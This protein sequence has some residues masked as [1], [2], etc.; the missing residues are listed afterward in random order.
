MRTQELNLLMIFD[1]IMVERSITRAAERLAMTQPA[2]SNAVSRMRALWKDELFVKNGRNIQPTAYAQNLW[3]KIKK[4]LGELTEAVDPTDFD[5]ATVKRTFKIAVSDIVV[6]A[7]WLPLRKMLKEQAPHINIHAIPYTDMSSDQMLEDAKVDLIIGVANIENNSTRREY[8]FSPHFV[9][10][11]RPGHPLNKENLSME[12]FCSA[13]HLFISLSGDITNT[14]DQVLAQHGLSRRIAFTVNHFAAITP[15][16]E[17]SDLLC[18]APSAPVI[19]AL[20]SGRLAG[21]K[22]PIELTPPQI[23][24]L[25]HKR[26]DRDIG[27]HWIRRQLKEIIQNAADK[28]ETALQQLCNES[29]VN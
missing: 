3:S 8:L 17:G 19:N 16:V 13:D 7:A 4:P 12:E 23:S 10:V 28:H 26:Q 21:T 11:M 18:I 6:D 22:P 24:L 5:P 27:L 20:Q 25:W 1:A 14:T 2:V 15:L 9:C 29:C